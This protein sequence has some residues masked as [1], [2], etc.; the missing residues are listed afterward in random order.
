MV[1]TLDVGNTNI[2]LSVYNH[3]SMLFSSRISTVSNKM[4]DEYAID[5]LNILK[6]NQCSR[7]GFEGAIIST[8]VP[9]LKSTLKKA[10]ERVFD[11]RVMVVSCNLKTGLNI[12]LDNPTTLGSDRICDAVAVKNLYSLPAVICDLGTATTIS[13]IDKDS[14][15][16]GGSI[17]PGVNSS[18]KTLSSVTAQLPH[19]D[20]R[21]NCT[22]IIGKDTASAMHSGVIF[23]MASF[24]DGMA[25]RYKEILGDET[26]LVATGGLS[27]LIVP[28]CK[29][30][31]ISNKNL[32]SDGL[33]MIYKM[34]I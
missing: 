12:Q 26:I 20:L 19:I 15:F 29:E 28:H 23:G 9:Q 27:D 32:V 1:I 16:L 8:V 18:L 25:Q 17:F 30:E 14:N 21:E 2:V 10:V 4:E 11:C 7:E 34:N 31:F 6:L 3:D 5:F 33:Y 13:A 24:M 22:E